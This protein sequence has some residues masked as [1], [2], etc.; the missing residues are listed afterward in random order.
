M[1]KII[2]IEGK[3]Y[4]ELDDKDNPIRI[5]ADGKEVGISHDELAT[6]RRE[7]VERKEAIK[8]LEA[9]IEPFKGIENPAEWLQNANKALETVAALPDKDKSVEE[10]VRAQVE[11]ATKPLHDKLGEATKEADALRLQLQSEA[12]GNSFSRSAYVRDKMIDPVMAADLF[13][14]RFSMK[15]GKV[16]ATNEKGEPLYGE[17]GIATFD[18]AMSQL[19]EA[20][21]YKMALL[22]GSDATGGGAAPN[23]GGGAPA[24][25]KKRSEMS[26]TEKTEYITKHG[27]EAFRKLSE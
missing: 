21:P 26:V 17:N 10:R 7:A 14:S 8:K 12:V 13:K 16:V 18:E 6:A 9:Q 2:E 1:W 19:V 23:G 24:T 11:A 25:G 15:D 5:L 4:V 22:K 27:Q 20:S 3:K